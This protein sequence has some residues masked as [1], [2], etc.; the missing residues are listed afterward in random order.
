MS[1]FI[2]SSNEGLQR[3][4][5]AKLYDLVG[6]KPLI[7]EIV[8]V[9][10]P[11]VSHFQSITN[12]SCKCCNWRL[13]VAYIII[14]NVTILIKIAIMYFDWV[15][16]IGWIDFQQMKICVD[17]ILWKNDGQPLNI[18]GVVNGN[19]NL[20]VS[21]GSIDCDLTTINNNWPTQS[22]KEKTSEDE[23]FH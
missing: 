5:K 9:K 2:S 10:I 3:T 4:Y 7:L 15:S 13:N 1:F 14:H 12:I 23:K 8:G 18:G 22:N 19:V 11:I 6:I 21:N 20:C 17:F 16:S